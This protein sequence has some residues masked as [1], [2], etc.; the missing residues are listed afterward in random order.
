MQN[1]QH[2]TA[3]RQY[4]AD[5]FYIHPKPI[6]PDELIQR[7]ITGMD[8]LRA[9][10]YE[11]GV[12]P[13]PSYWNPGDSPQKFCKIEMPQITNRAIMELVSHPA[14]GKVAHEIT[15]ARMVQIWW[16][17][18]LGKPPTPPNEVIQ[19]NV[20]WHQDRQYWKIWEEGSE[21]FTAWVALTDVT[22]KSGAMRFVRGSHKWGLLDKGDFYGQ[23]HE[24]Q[25]VGITEATANGGETWQEVDAILAPGSVSFHH[26]LTFHASGPNLSSEMRRSFAIHMRTEKS[27]SVNGQRKGLSAFINDFTYCPVIYGEVV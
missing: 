10:E 19:T 16:V 23:D 17:Q 4:E 8:A 18:L 20:G 3:R 26:N 22:A 2:S 25:R 12:P 11:T 24:A 15:G 6:I 7:A 9:G 1:E 21:L 14:I 27:R 13:Q 5:G